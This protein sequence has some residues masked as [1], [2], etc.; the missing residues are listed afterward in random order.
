VKL[1]VSVNDVARAAGVSI[2]TVSNVLNRPQKVRPQ[3]RRRVEDA[4]GSLGFVRNEAARRLTGARSRMVAYVMLNHSNP[5]FS[6][7]AGAIEDVVGHH[8]LGLI[9]MSSN[10]DA[11]RES[12]Y[13]EMLLE[14]RVRGVLITAVSYASAQ[15]ERLRALG[16]PVVFVDRSAADPSWCSV[17]VDDVEGGRQAVTHL[18]DQGHRRIAVVGPADVPQVADRLAGAAEVAR[19]L[20]LG[21]THLRTETLTVAAG[22]DAGAKLLGI[23]SSS[24][25]TGVFCANDLLALGLLQELTQ[26]GLRIPDDIAIVGYDDIEFAAAAA[27]PLTSLRQPRAE[28]GRAAVELLLEETEGGPHQHS[29]VRFTP[30]LVVRQSSARRRTAPAQMVS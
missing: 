5:F 2:G 15:F 28:M 23:S 14:N 30:E 3:T 9:T 4:I 19:G 18:A 6:D 11:D 17:G 8:H 29:H 16:V 20:G 12:E 24:R 22:R 13:L 1:T 7:L 26:Y 25:P 21:F 27:I 10:H